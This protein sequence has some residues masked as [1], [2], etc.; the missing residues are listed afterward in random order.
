MDQNH[1]KCPICGRDM[2]PGRSLNEH[3]LIPKKYKGKETITIHR[4]CHSKIHSLFTE[5][6]LERYYH[7]PERIME[8][9]EMIKFVKWVRKKPPEF[10]DGNKRS[11]LKQGKFHGKSRKWR[12]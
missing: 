9:E 10:M 3:H 4:I 12:K 11:S 5:K 2:I 1:Q 8:H 7:T 6:E